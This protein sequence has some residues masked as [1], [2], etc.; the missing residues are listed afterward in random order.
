MLADL[1]AR[2]REPVRE[3]VRFRQQQQ[4]SVVVDEGREDDEFGLNCVVRTVWAVV[5]HTSHPT[6]V[7]AVD[8]VTHC[9]R[10]QLE[11]AGRIGLG[12]LGDEDARL[13]TDVA[14]ERLAEA[15]IGAG[16]PILI[17]L[18]EGPRRREWMITELARRGIEQNGALVP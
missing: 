5:A 13:G 2:I 3:L 12:Q 14:A 16:G 9:P 7:V 8:A 4:A 6:A 17:G 1:S 10:D 15:A 11:V 18:R